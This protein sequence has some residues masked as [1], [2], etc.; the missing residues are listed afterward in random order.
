MRCAIEV[1]KLN[2]VIHA[3]KVYILPGLKP[4]FLC[5]KVSPGTTELF[6]FEKIISG[7]E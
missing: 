1:E 3:R 4:Q 6:F 2:M 7:G 5:D